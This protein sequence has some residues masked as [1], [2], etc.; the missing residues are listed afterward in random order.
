MH[1]HHGQSPV[2]R[3]IADTKLS[4]RLCALRKARLPPTD[5]RRTKWRSRP[6]NAGLSECGCASAHAPR[7]PARPNFSRH[8]LW[9][10]RTHATLLSPAAFRGPS[11][12]GLG[13]RVRN[14]D[15]DQVEPARDV[16]R[17]CAPTAP[18][19]ALSSGMRTSQRRKGSNGNF[20]TLP[21]LSQAWL[22]KP[23]P[24]A[25]SCGSVRGGRLE[26]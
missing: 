13:W 7:V 26:G 5:E 4:L 24:R 1:G 2:L 11:R 8:V 6:N 17:H 20:A 22:A 23:S 21:R 12:L 3:A 25:V 18:P 14:E 10:A 19:C 9:Q 16:E 15:H